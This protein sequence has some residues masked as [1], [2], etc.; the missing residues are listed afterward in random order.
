M[1][2]KHQLIANRKIIEEKYASFVVALRQ[3]VKRK[4][5]EEK[6]EFDEF[7]S[8]VW[9]LSIS[10]MKARIKRQDLCRIDDVFDF[11]EEGACFIHCDIFKQIYKKF[12]SDCSMKELNYPEEFQSYIMKHTIAQLFESI[13]NFKEYH[14]NE[15]F[16]ELS[17][18]FEKIDVCVCKASEV[19]EL[20]SAIATILN[21][22]PSELKLHY[23]EGGKCA[24]VTFLI[25]EYMANDIFAPHKR[26][27]MSQ[28]MEIESLSVRWLQ[29]SVYRKVNYSSPETGN[30]I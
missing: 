2:L 7:R 18:K 3:C 20:T 12:C 13:P 26:F 23:V 8:Y 19:V 17:F 30:I 27:S 29:C 10:A 4:Q 16:K 6:I 5:K 14:A 28:T 9:T 21:S 25:P 15:A 11:A 1:D 24:I 22:N